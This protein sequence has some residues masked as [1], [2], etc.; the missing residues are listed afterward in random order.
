MFFHILICLQDPQISSVVLTRFDTQVAAEA[1]A[2]AMAARDL[3]SPMRDPSKFSCKRVK[4]P[5]STAEW[6]A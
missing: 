2:E 3:T 5:S 4:P 6:R 1:E